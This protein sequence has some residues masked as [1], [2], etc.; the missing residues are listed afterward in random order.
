M[1]D[2]VL[3]GDGY[4]IRTSSFQ[5]AVYRPLSG[6]GLLKQSVT[7][8]AVWHALW[9]CF[10]AIRRFRPDLPLCLSAELRAGF[11]LQPRFELTASAGAGV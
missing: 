9:H 7:L 11:H 4:C 10:D 6:C 1:G 2:G 8:C 3:S 5:L